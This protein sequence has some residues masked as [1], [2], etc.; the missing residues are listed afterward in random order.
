MTSQ[1]VT[2]LVRREVETGIRRIQAIKDLDCGRY[3]RLKGF[4]FGFRVVLLELNMRLKMIRE[5]D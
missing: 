3:A 5:K 1:L 4:L 2:L